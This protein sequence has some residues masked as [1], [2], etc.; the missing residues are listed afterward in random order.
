MSFRV[1]PMSS[2]EY[3]VTVE[4][5]LG[6]R[7]HRV[8]IGPALLSAL[9]TDHERGAQVVTAAIDYLDDAHELR[10]LAPYVDLDAFRSRRGF[11]DEVR[12]R[13]A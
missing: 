12:R 3:D 6:V 9:G 13:I 8:V 1:I 2:G 10:A 5:A 7:S 4:S 11:V